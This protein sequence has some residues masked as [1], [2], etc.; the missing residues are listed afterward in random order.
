MK[1]II[2]VVLANDVKY[3]INGTLADLAVYVQELIEQYGP[4]ARIDVDKEFECYSDYVY[5]YVRVFGKR[6]ETD[7]EYE[8]RTAEE[9]A[10][11]AKMEAREQAEFARLAAKFGG[12]K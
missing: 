1:K 3:N 2:E 7:A 6:E 4:T 12:N 10:Y 11:M 8:K 5:A 9:A